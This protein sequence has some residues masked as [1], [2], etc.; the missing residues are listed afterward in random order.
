MLIV[1]TYLDKSSLHGIGLFAAEDIKKSQLVGKIT[2]LDVKM[3]KI[4]IASRYLDWM[5]DVY[6]DKGD[7]IQTYMDDMRFMN[8]SEDPNCL[9]EE[10]YCI[11][12]KDIKIGQELTCDYTKL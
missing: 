6:V 1:K 4:N 12:I 5:I 10:N 7:Y 2:N 9:D 11:A 3:N 8:H